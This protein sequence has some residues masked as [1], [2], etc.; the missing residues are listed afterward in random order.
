MPAKYK[1]VRIGKSV[2]DEHRK[3]MQDFLGRKLKRNEVVHHIDDDPRNNNLE[4]LKL[5]TLE[6]HSRL[7]VLRGDT[8]WQSTGNHA[9]PKHPSISAYRKGC[10]CDECKEIQRLRVKAY[11]DQK[12]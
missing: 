7:H 12:K 8:G 2:I 9:Q 3:I 4:N 1:K 5:M 11:R 6:E 10:R